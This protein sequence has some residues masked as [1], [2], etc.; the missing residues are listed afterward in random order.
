MQRRQAEQARADLDLS[1]LEVLR[2]QVKEDPANVSKWQVAVD[3]LEMV[4]DAG[5]NPLIAPR[6]AAL[7][8][9]VE[10]GLA[11]AQRDQQLLEELQEI[12]ISHGMA[13]AAFPDLIADAFRDGGMDFEA[14]DP[15]P[16]VHRLLSRPEVVRTELT[17]FL[18]L[19]AGQ[20]T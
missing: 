7:R 12:L 2:D 4:A 10:A 15:T 17:G 3:Q 18:D 6:L 1:K 5:A 20:R 9:E 13:G 14:D 19:L 11:D 8:Q 16:A